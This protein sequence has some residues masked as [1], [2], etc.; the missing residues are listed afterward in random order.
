MLNPIGGVERGISHV[1][2]CSWGKVLLGSIPFEPQEFFDGNAGK[3]YE[4]HR[5]VTN[6]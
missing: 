6:R 3:R 5:H 2:E 4:T 1:A